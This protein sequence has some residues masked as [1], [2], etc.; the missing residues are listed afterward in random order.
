VSNLNAKR[1]W[2]HAKDYVEAMW[3]MLQQDKP[4]DFVIATNKTYSVKDFINECFEQLG[5]MGGASS[6]M[7]WEGSGIN[8]KLVW[9]T[10]GCPTDGLPLVVVNPKYF[11]PSEVE[12]LLGDASKA[13]KELGWTPKYDFKSLVKDMLEI[14]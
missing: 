5:W 13:Q 9:N 6:H 3:R 7:H 12:V 11:R 2:G 8:E 10:L 1:D 4:E 14:N